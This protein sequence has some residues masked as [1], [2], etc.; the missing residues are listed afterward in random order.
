RVIEPIDDGLADDA[1]EL[2]EVDDHAGLR[3]DGAAHRDV[4]RVVMPVRDGE[5]AE[6]A[7]V[8]LRRPALDPVAVPGREREAAGAR[9]ARGVRHG[10]VSR[11]RPATRGRSEERRVGK[12]GSCRLS[13]KL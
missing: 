6:E 4:E 9:R 7:L 12:E 3:V 1:L 2:A 13:R 10:K 11:N 5:T 8:L